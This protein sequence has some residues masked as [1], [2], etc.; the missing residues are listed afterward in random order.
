MTEVFD[1]ARR[2]ILLW[3]LVIIRAALYSLVTLGAAWLT[4]TS[5]LDVGALHF[6]D[7]VTLAVGIV[8]LWGN[9]MMSF[10]D[11]TAAGIAANKPPIGS[12]DGAIPPKVDDKPKP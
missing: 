7:K 12:D 8:V 9:Q 3:K 10:L 5:G 4:A 11:K 6:W 1:S 2:T